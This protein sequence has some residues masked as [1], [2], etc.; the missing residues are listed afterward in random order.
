MNSFFAHFCRWPLVLAVTTALLGSGRPVDAAVDLGLPEMPAEE[1]G[2]AIPGLARVPA[3]FQREIDAGRF[4]GVVWLIA[5]DGSVASHGAIGSSDLSKGTPMTEDTLFRIYSMT[6]L[7]TSV[8][9]LT[10][11]EEG[12]INLDD[13]VERFLPELADRKVF[14]GGSAEAPQLEPARGS[15]TIRQL[16][17]H[18]SGFTYDVFASGVLREIWSKPDLWRSRTLKDFVSKIATLPL[19]HQPGTQFTYSFGMDVLGAIIEVVT[20]QDLETAM[21]QRIMAPLGMTRT[22][23]APSAAEQANLPVIYH[24][25]PNGTLEKDEVWTQRGTLEFP[26]GGGGLYSTLH[27]YARFGQMLLDGGEFEGVRILGRKTVEMMTSNQIGFLGA[28]GG[29]TP[30]EFGFGVRVRPENSEREKALGSPG[31]FGW[32][33]AATT[34]VSID[35]KERVLL[36]MFMQHSTYNEDRIFERFQNTAYGAIE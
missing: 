26:S 35:P 15:I 12:R 27:D 14:V 7:L 25:T 24:R 29:W 30:T 17:T 1:L 19:A 33:G 11:I 21:R 18:T 22:T 3:M 20:G 23:F 28:P 36:L 34:W 16:L 13:P 31:T 2:F 9:V 32:D 8:T 10:L 4:S 5:R 6:K